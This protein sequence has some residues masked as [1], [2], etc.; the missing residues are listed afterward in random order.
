MIMRERERE[1]ERTTEE[2]R[3]KYNGRRRTHIEIILNKYKCGAYAMR[4]SY[5]ILKYTQPKK[6]MFFRVQAKWE[7]KTTTFQFVYLSFH[8]SCWTVRRYICIY[9]CRLT[10]S[11]YFIALT[12]KKQ[13]SFHICPEWIHQIVLIVLVVQQTLLSMLFLLLLLLALSSII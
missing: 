4:F 9:I 8:T 1:Q 6:K 11:I 13:L 5:L 10:Q 7:A 3:H 2:K 12:L